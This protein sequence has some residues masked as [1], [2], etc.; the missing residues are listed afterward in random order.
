MEVSTD[1]SAFTV[2]ELESLHRSATIAA[3]AQ[4]PPIATAAFV[5]LVERAMNAEC[6]AELDLVLRDLEGGRWVVRGVVGSWSVVE[7]GTGRAIV[8][9]GN[10]GIPGWYLA[11]DIAGEPKL[12]S[13]RRGR[14]GPIIHSRPVPSG[15]IDRIGPVL[16]GQLDRSMG[17]PVRVGNIEAPVK[18]MRRDGHRV[19]VRAYDGLVVNPIAD[20]VTLDIGSS[21][22]TIA[23]HVWCDPLLRAVEVIE[24]DDQLTLG[25]A[26]FGTF[27]D[28]WA[29]YRAEFG[30][31][32]GHLQ[33]SSF[34]GWVTADGHWEL[35]ETPASLLLVCRG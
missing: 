7:V 3:G 22:L 8:S 4:V 31:T 10:P 15:S 11:A 19:S 35:I 28:A 13:W 9:T 2:D 20:G 14:S 5:E 1:L 24:A 32:S 33:T 6:A 34:V 30:P 21:A 18:L 29:E 25:Q 16:L 23:A 17:L 27:P 12:L 26:F